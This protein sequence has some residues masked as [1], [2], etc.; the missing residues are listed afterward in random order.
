MISVW[1]GWVELF[2][3]CQSRVEPIKLEFVLFTDSK[4]KSQFT[5]FVSVECSGSDQLE[6]SG[7]DQLDANGQTPSAMSS[8]IDS[9][10]N[11]FLEMGQRSS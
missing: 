2:N 10:K 3:R 8:F 6:C 1:F 5:N 9:Y 11:K 7:S 4:L